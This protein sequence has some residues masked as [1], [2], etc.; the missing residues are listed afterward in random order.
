VVGNDI[1]SKDGFKF[2]AA[3]TGL[4]GNWTY[5]ALEHGYEFCRP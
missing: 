3:M 4:E 2:S 1:A 5:E